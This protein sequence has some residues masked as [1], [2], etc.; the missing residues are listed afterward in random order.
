MNGL[1]RNFTLEQ[2]KVF[3]WVF[4]FLRATSQYRTKPARRLIVHG[5][6]DTSKLYLVQAVAY[7]AHRAIAL[8][9]FD[10]H[11]NV[12]GMFALIGIASFKIDGGMVIDSAFAMNRE[13]SSLFLKPLVA[14]K[15]AQLRTM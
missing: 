1:V 11:R 6:G 13:S 3:C 4:C 12:V 8:R 2:R 7:F 5:A 14:V 10:F 9:G 15:L